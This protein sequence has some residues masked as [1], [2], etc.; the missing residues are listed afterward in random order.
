M[1]DRPTRTGK[2]HRAGRRAAAALA[3]GVVVAVAAGRATAGDP[4]EDPSAIVLIG[5]VEPTGT[6]AAAGGVV[7]RHWRLETLAPRP[8]AAAGTHA[9]LETLARSYREA[10]FLRCLAGINRSL[11]PD[12][13]LQLGHR[14]EAAQAGT[15]AA[16]C[17]LGA[18]DEGRARDLLRR[19]SVRDLMQPHLLR[20]TTPAFQRI[21]DDEQQAAQRR[22]WI[23][24]DMRSEPDGAAIHVN[25]IKRCPAAPCRVHLLRGEH[26]LTAEKL[27]HRPRTVTPVLDGDHAVTINLDPASAE[28]T[29]H[30]LAAALGAGVDPSGVEIPRAAAS[31]FGAGLL[32]LVWNHNLQVHAAAYQAGQP[33]AD[34]RRGRRRRR[35]AARRGGRA[36]RLAREGRL[37]EPRARRARFDFHVPRFVVVGVGRRGRT[38]EYRAGV[39]VAPVQGSPR[40][41]IPL[42]GRKHAGSIFAYTV[43]SKKRPPRMS[44]PT[45]LHLERVQAT[46]RRLRVRI[47]EGPDRDRVME[48]YG[49]RLGIGTSPANELTL[50]DPTVSHYHLELRCEDGVL[51]KDLGSRNGTF[52]GDVRLREAVVPIGTRIRIGRTVLALLDATIAPPETP[53]PPPDVPG[54]VAAS[55]TM[56]Q[57]GRTVERLAQSTV[58]VL[59]QGETG[60]G[61]E[62]VAR[63]I[64]EMSARAKQPFIVVDPRRAARDVDRVA[65]VRTRA[66]R[67]HRRGAPAGRGVR[68]GARRLDLPRRDR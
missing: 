17:A 28:E 18:G 26:V 29:R 53:L 16:A 20:G 19:L 48:H 58:S 32:V 61:K 4:A 68:A 6:L 37:A 7:P 14:A 67:L 25:G 10:D 50:T 54:L 15:L 39:P 5:G 60:T 2:H 27:G 3:V 51:V 52:V 64:H 12:Q 13:L 38:C 46:V 66:G 56:Q 9:R 65:T 43:R 55:S 11:D 24:V 30:Q 42:A 49:E 40:C 59:I 22:G 21:A 57:I 63:A 44:E 33:F 41:R 8:V 45:E 36:A 47:I 1:S 34:A 35:G 23:A 31:A 62:M